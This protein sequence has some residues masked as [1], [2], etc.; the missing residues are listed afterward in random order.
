MAL[1]LALVSLQTLPLRVDD[2]YTDNRHTNTMTTENPVNILLLNELLVL[3]W[4]TYGDA[5]QLTTKN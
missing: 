2:A 5:T 1:G 4:C 3:T